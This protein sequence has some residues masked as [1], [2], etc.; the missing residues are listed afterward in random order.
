M[1]KYIKGILSVA[2]IVGMFW[3]IQEQFHFLDI[4]WITTLKDNTNIAKIEKNKEED[5]GENS[6]KGEVEGKKQLSNYVQIHTQSNSDIKVNVE[7][8]DDKDEIIR[9][10]SFRKYLGS[11][12]GMLF[13][14]KERVDSAFWMKDMKIP[15]DI[16]FIDAEY[17][18]VDIKDNNAPCIENF[19]PEIRS[20][21][22]YKYVLEVNAG[23]CDSNSIKIGDRITLHLD[24]EN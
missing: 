12:D 9:G 6:D 24:S 20:S 7:V 15:L 18:I 8:S 11:Y 2:V 5:K 19:C 22:M 13:I 16:L 23:F 3:K 17:K 4:R 1:I 21:S 14:F 10:L